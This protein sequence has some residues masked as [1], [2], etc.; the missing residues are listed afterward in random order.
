[1]TMRILW[2]K[3]GNL[4]PP[5]T[6]GRLRS[7]HIVS[8]LARRHRVIVVTTRGPGEDPQ[9]LASELSHCEEIVSVPYQAPK[10]GSA[11]FAGALLRSWLSP[12]PVDMW[13]WRVPAVKIAVDRL[14]AER[15]IDVCVADFLLAIGNVP[16]AGPAPVVFFSH[17]V[18]HMIWKRLCEAEK[19][20]LRR[21]LLE[22]EW[23]KMRRYE[24]RAC[25]QAKIT[26]AVSD[27]DREIL[28]ANA[29][30]A[31]VHTVP[32]GVD[33]SYFMPN[34]YREAQNTLVFTGSMDWVPNE[35]AIFYFLEKILPP[36]RRE[37]PGVTLSVVGRDPTPRLLAAAAA[38]GVR[39]TGTV[40]DVRPYV[41]A[42]AV[43]IVPLR[44]GGG[45]RLKIFE[46][47]AMAKPVVSTAIGAEGLP[48]VPGEHFLQADDPSD[49]ARAVVS[50]LRDPARRKALGMAGRKLVEERY[51][52]QRVAREFETRCQEAID[53][54]RGAAEKKL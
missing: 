1:M 12:L 30:G 7:F 32:T 11:A 48:L 52:W 17:N 45:T 9:D 24:R 20:P 43:Y 41:A 27:V 10:Q 33:V 26:V 40:A 34:G 23:R 42:G 3:V 35:D 13:K 28:A 29:P 6:G 53:L 25:A 39:V 2:V 5:N 50:L 51:S 46:A 44:I 16:R 8:E 21:A 15:K 4:W 18:E 31:G 47:L 14:M 38:A 49:F 19:H 37:I 36:V 54:T 22:I